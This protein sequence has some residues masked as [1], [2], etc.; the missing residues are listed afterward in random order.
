MENPMFHF[1]Y[2][3][4]LAQ[5]LLWHIN[6]LELLSVHLALRQFQPL[7]LAKYVL[8]RTDNTAAVSYINQLGGV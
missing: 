6:W 5:G 8:V 4:P 7:L 3:P 2:V 1:S